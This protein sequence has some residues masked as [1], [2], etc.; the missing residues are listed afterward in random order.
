MSKRKYEGPEV[1]PAN[2]S[3]TYIWVRPPCMPDWQRGILL[4]K[5]DIP[6]LIRR[7]QEH[8]PKAEPI[9]EPITEIM[10]KVKK[11]NAAMKALMRGDMPKQR[12]RKASK[13]MDGCLCPD[14]HPLGGIKS[15]RRKY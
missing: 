9:G 1:E 14:C 6:E 10:R 7:L 15:S 11:P 2:T 3:D 13:H 12:K 4:L 8:A 5:V